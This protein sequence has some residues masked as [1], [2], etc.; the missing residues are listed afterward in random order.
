MEAFKFIGRHDQV[1]ISCAVILCEAGNPNTRCA[2]GCIPGNTTSAPHRHG[3]EAVLETAKH[4]ISQGPL[5]LRRSAD[6][7]RKAAYF[8]SAWIQTG[9]DS[10][11]QDNG[12][13]QQP[14]RALEDLSCM[15]IGCL[16]C[17]L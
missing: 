2:Q 10:H 14:I 16:A 1:Y 8:P 3:R 4:F 9:P 17:S 7:E 13:T 15:P 11:R 12:A 5:R 6:S